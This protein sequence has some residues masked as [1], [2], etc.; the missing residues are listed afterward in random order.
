MMLNYLL[1]LTAWLT[2]FVITKIA[3]SLPLSPLSIHIPLDVG[4]VIRFQ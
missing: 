4:I 2:T 1:L 3:E